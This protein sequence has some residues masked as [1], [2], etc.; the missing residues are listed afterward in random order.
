MVVSSSPSAELWRRET[1]SDAAGS[2]DGDDETTIWGWCNGLAGVGTSRVAL[3]DATNAAGV[4][5]W[6]VLRED[7]QAE[8]SL[9]D[10]LCCGSAGRALFMLDAGEVFEDSSLAERGEQLFADALDRARREGRFR[11]ANHLP[12]LPKFGLFTGLSGVGYV[13]LQL[14][15]REAGVELPNVTRLE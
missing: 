3:A 8:P 7:L 5:D 12:T 6:T 13:A 10:S 9:E 14:E 2:P 1:D 11:L 4:E 15:A